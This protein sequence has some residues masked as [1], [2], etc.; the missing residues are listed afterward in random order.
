MIRERQRALAREDDFNFRRLRNSVNRL[1]KSYR[2]KYYAANV[3]QLR[4]CEPRRWWKEVKKLAGMQAASR[5]D[6][7]SVLRNIDQG[8]FPNLTALANTINKVFLAPMS[9]F[10]PLAPR[11]S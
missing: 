6:T 1:R 4:D 5:T 9:T 10:T 2:A 11:T 8:P 7:I 3:E